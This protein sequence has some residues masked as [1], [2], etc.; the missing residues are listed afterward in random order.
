MVRQVRPARRASSWKAALAVTVA[1]AGLLW[2]LLACYESPMAF[3][4][5][6]KELAFT[7]MEPYQGNGQEDLLLPGPHCYRLMVLRDFEHLRVVEQSTD[8]M[9][10]GPAYSPDGKQIC[11]LRLPLL[12]PQEFEKLKESSKGGTWGG[13]VVEP[14]TSA[15]SQGVSR[16]AIEQTPGTKLL[17][18]SRLEDVARFVKIAEKDTPARAELVVRDARTFRVLAR[19]PTPLFPRWDAIW[20]TGK[21][22]NSPGL[23]YLVS[24]TTTRPQYGPKG[25]WVYFCAGGLAMGVNPGTKVAKI[26]AAPADGAAISP[27]GKTLAAVRGDVIGF[28][29]TDGRRAVYRR[30]DHK[31]LP[32]ML[33]WRDA[34]TLAVLRVADG[35]GRK[36]HT[37]EFL[38]ADGTTSGSIER[39]VPSDGNN[40]PQFALAPDGRHMALYDG[41]EL[42][43]LDADGRVLKRLKDKEKDTLVQPVFTP[44][45]RHV[46]VKRLAEDPKG[47]ARVVEIVKFTAAGQEVKRV[48]V[49]K[50]KPGTTR[51]AKAT[52]QPKGD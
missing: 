14:S 3:S 2:H 48:A 5:D 37:L 42:F 23:G 43:F 19:V 27:D 44:D 46:V 9:L 49:P 24:Y 45:S 26:L 32:A 39:I 16:P 8:H 13:Y 51:P 25:K 10:S 34:S 30:W 33:T 40:Y 6:G 1:A 47:Y 29:R 28:V 22:E 18:L 50:L 20:A 31:L 4:P 38:R 11:Y 12:S 52:T 21:K 36:G 41:H 35:E 15:P 7:T 17:A